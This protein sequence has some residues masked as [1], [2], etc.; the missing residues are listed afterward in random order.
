MPSF[1]DFLNVEEQKRVMR[2]A[3]KAQTTINSVVDVPWLACGR[4]QPIKLAV[5]RHPNRP[6]STFQSD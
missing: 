3:R 4:S 6:S 2:D 5:D 1:H